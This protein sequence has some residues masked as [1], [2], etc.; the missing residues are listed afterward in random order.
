MQRFLK[1]QRVFLQSPVAHLH[2]SELANDDAKRVLDLGPDANFALLDFIDERIDRA[3]RLVQFSALAR[4]HGDAPAHIRLD[5]G[6]LV[7]ALI[8]MHRH[9]QRFLPR[10][11]ARCL[12]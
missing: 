12:R 9:G 8:P 1:L 5:I 7:G 6:P 11:A 3:A 2:K 10:A 4:T